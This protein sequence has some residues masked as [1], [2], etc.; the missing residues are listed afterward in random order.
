MNKIKFSS[1]YE[2]LP[3]NWEGTHARLV[4][5]S[6]FGVNHFKLSFPQFIEYDTK[7]RGK[8]GNYDLSFDDG[9]LLVFLHYNTGKPF[10]TI[11]RFTPSKSR[12][13]K[14]R[15]THTFKLIKPLEDK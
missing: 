7:F 14:Q 3:R 9:I 15:E 8:T 12:Y 11:R 10:T 6:L 1:D 4:S 5:V 13:Y 2:K